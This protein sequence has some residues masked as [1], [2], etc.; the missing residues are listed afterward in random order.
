MHTKCSAIKI[1]FYSNVIFDQKN[2]TWNRG[3]TCSAWY[4][5]VVCCVHSY[6]LRS[7]QLTLKIN[8]G[9]YLQFYPKF[10]F[11][12]FKIPLSLHW[13]MIVCKVHSHSPCEHLRMNTLVKDNTSIILNMEPTISALF[14]RYSCAIVQFCWSTFS[15]RYSYVFVHYMRIIKHKSISALLFLLLLLLSFSATCLCVGFVLIFGS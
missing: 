7:A 3:C 9:F 12:L 1:Q 15:L 6:A 4:V 2:V 11:L 8:G 13:K 5:Y 14:V 10:L